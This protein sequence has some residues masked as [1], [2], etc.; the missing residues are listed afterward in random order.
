MDDQ[1]RARTGVRTFSLL[2]G[3]VWGG[4]WLYRVH[5]AIRASESSGH[6]L[7]SDLAYMYNEPVFLRL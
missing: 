6:P 2:G 5:T 3:D 1:R 4:L 7:R